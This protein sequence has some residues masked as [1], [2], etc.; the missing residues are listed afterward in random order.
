MPPEEPPA[1]L[2]LDIALRFHL[3]SAQ[4]KGFLDPCLTHSGDCRFHSTSALHSGTLLLA[5]PRL[6]WLK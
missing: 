5:W 6:W 3:L 4:Y 2:S 1:A